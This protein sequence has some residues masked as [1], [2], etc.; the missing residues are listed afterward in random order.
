MRG[1]EE[2]RTEV[3][4]NNHADGFN[5]GRKREDSASDKEKRESRY[6]ENGTEDWHK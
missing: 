6:L 1:K 3:E 5:V 4:G 2:V